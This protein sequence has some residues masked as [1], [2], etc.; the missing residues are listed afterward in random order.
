MEHQQEDD[1]DHNEHDKPSTYLF[2]G[3][4]LNRAPWQYEKAMAHH[5]AMSLLVFEALEG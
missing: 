4:V 1:M 3:P 5:C 2:W